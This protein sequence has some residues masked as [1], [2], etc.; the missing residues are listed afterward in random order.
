MKRNAF[1]A[2]VVLAGVAAVVG[3]AGAQAAA[4]DE[5]SD[6]LG[7]VRASAREWVAHPDGVTAMA[8]DGTGH[9]LATA[10]GEG[11]IKVW[12]LSGGLLAQAPSRGRR[13]FGLLWSP[14]GKYLLSLEA[15]AKI[16]DPGT[17][18]APTVVKGYWH[19]DNSIA[20][21]DAGSG[22]LASEWATP[23]QSLLAA[24]F[25]SDGAL[26]VSGST[27]PLDANGY[28]GQPEPFV[29]WRS[30]PEGKVQRQ[31]PIEAQA[32]GPDGEKFAGLVRSP[33][34]AHQTIEVWTRR[35]STFQPI[36][37]RTA[38]VKSLAFS[39]DGKYLLASTIGA[40]EIKMWEARSGRFVRHAAV[41][42]DSP[43]DTMHMALGGRWGLRA[44]VKSAL[45]DLETGTYQGALGQGGE[46][47]AAAMSADGKRGA[48]A[49]LARAGTRVGKGGREGVVRLYDLSQIQPPDRFPAWR[50]T[51]QGRLSD[52]LPL[53]GAT[54]VG[55]GAQADG[56]IAAVA[57]RTAPIYSS[58]EGQLLRW[59]LSRS[60]LLEAFDLHGP[61][62]SPSSPMARPVAPED[63]E[64]SR[65]TS[66]RLPLALA[67]DGSL[68]AVETVSDHLLTVEIHDAARPTSP[69]VLLRD[70]GEVMLIG[71]AFTPGSRF[72]VAWRWSERGWELVRWDVKSGQATVLL[73][74]Q[75]ADFLNSSPGRRPTSAY[76]V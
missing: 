40:G 32:I 15:P 21:W 12:D 71:P 72:F 76:A 49:T 7:E 75:T 70:S 23:R 62:T 66:E 44:G 60:A 20:V 67:D 51:T 42:L 18:S 13:I 65:L 2:A 56:D 50:D 63:D 26:I 27:S 19:E 48:L 14:D 45:W 58:A 36:S 38:S 59:S 46:D 41:A 35:G 22:A 5:P 29:Q 17:A 68:V 25:A 61:S 1:L 39:P 9:R 6:V 8:F 74:G 64:P 3:R 16:V 34:Y 53:N 37:I 24:R 4:R 73:S 47:D 69:G 33:Y 43:Y 57:L 28:S 30:F 52:G 10:G 54:M 31:E 11:A 55:L